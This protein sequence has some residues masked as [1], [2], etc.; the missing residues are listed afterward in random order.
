MKINIVH[1]LPESY[2]VHDIKK[3]VFISKL[4]AI[5]CVYLQVL[6]AA[7]VKQMNKEKVS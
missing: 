2:M 3:Q 5:Y 1:L 6:N 7:S 4:M